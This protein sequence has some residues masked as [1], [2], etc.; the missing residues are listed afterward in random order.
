MGWILVSFFA[1]K[2]YPLSSA[3]LVSNFETLTLLIQLPHIP[4]NYFLATWINLNYP[5]LCYSTIWTSLSYPSLTVELSLFN[6]L[7]LFFVVLIHQ[8]K[9]AYVQLLLQKESNN[10]I[11]KSITYYLH[12]MLKLRSFIKDPIRDPSFAEWMKFKGIGKSQ[13]W[14]ASS[15]TANSPS[16]PSLTEGK[17]TLPTLILGLPSPPW[18]DHLPKPLKEY[19]PGSQSPSMPSLSPISIMPTQNSPLNLIQAQ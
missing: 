4:R 8:M 16:T 10:L 6:S 1:G 14:S 18:P 9:S 12:T 5:F 2:P 17:S 3:K 7:A 19:Q 11:L 15:L 13:E